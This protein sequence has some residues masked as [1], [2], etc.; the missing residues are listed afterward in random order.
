[1]PAPKDR[2]HYFPR[3][4]KKNSESVVNLLKEVSKKRIKILDFSFF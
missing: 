3:L 4:Q 2:E 1:M